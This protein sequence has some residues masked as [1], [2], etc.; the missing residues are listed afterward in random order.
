MSINITELCKPFLP[1]SVIAQKAV[2]LKE[3]E[4]GIFCAIEKIQPIIIESIAQL[5]VDNQLLGQLISFYQNGILNGIGSRNVSSHDEVYQLIHPL[6]L[7]KIPEIV[8]SISEECK[9]KKESALALLSLISDV[10]IGVLGKLITQNE[11]KTED[12]EVILSQ[13]KGFIK[14]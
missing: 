1:L 13:Q 6:L 4:E 5:K 7:N 10:C 9:I 3:S 12:V 14:I 2:Q 11:M 8:H